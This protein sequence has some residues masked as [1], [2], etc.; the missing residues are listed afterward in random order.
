MKLCTLVPVALALAALPSANAG[1]LSYGIGVSRLQL[2]GRRVL[3]RRRLYVRHSHGWRIHP[4]CYP[5][6][7]RRAGE[8]LRCVCAHRPHA[9]SVSCSW[10]IVARIS[11]PGVGHRSGLMGSICFFFRIHFMC[12]A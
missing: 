4:S 5:R 10:R 3:R 12:F 8:V 9:H 6:L 1:L 7:Q 11:Q 2:L